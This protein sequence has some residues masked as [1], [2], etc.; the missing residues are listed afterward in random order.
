VVRE[1]AATVDRPVGHFPTTCEN[2]LPNRLTPEKIK[3][4]FRVGWRYTTNGRKLPGGSRFVLGTDPTIDDR[5]NGRWIF[6]PRRAFPSHLC[7]REDNQKY[8]CGPAS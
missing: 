7:N 5:R 1:P 3:A 4:G 2:K 6:I 8:N